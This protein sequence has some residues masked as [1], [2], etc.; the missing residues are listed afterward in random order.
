MMRWASDGLFQ[1]LGS[2]A[3]AFSAASCSW[4]RSKSKMPPQQSQGL[5]DGF[6][7]ILKFGTH[8]SLELSKG[9]D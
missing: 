1:R 2:S 3:R 6:D 4:A 5:L 7:G 9:L 8:G